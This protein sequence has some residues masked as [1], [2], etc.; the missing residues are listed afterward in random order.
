[1][2]MGRS[3][4]CSGSNSRNTQIPRRGNIY[5]DRLCVS[6]RFSSSGSKRDLDAASILMGYEPIHCARHSRTEHFVWND[7]PRKAAKRK[8][9]SQGNEGGFHTARWFCNG[10]R[11]VPGNRGMEEYCAVANL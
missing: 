10:C 9:L 4:A 5:D 3:W 7:Y 11:C 2:I 6:D 1:M 8:G